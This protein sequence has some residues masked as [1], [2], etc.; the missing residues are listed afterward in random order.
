MHL[1]FCATELGDDSVVEGFKVVR[2]DFE[3]VYALREITTDTDVDW[4]VALPFS[5]N[6]VFKGSGVAL[7]LWRA[8][9]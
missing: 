5:L 1:L 2:A 3:P 6:N 9:K 7:C 8:E 4:I